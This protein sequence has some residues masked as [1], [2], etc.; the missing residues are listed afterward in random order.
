MSKINIALIFS[1]IFVFV[2]INNIS[3]VN[4]YIFEL[5]PASSSSLIYEIK[6]DE[7]LKIRIYEL[8]QRIEKLK[9]DYVEFFNEKIEKLENSI[10][11]LCPSEKINI[12]HLIS[13]TKSSIDRFNRKK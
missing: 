1:I 5:K 4:G 3:E 8:T 13:D 10:I 11:N 6:Q 2:V 9:R 7:I 12:L